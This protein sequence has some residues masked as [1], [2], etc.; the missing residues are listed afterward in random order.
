MSKVAAGFGPQAAGAVAATDYL[1]QNPA[2]QQGV[3][4]RTQ[5]QISRAQTNLNTAKFRGQ[6]TFVP[7]TQAAQD[8]VDQTVLATA[9]A[10][11]TQ[12]P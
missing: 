10:A 11:G 5:Q 3:G 2:T 8:V 9:R 6:Q 7:V 4:S 1:M 12:S